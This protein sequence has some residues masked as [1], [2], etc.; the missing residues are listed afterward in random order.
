RSPWQSVLIGTA[1]AENAWHGRHHPRRRRGHRQPGGTEPGGR[2]GDPGTGQVPQREQD[3]HMGRLLARVR[4]AEEKLAGLTQALQS[5]W[6]EELADARQALEA[7]AVAARR[8]E[9][10]DEA[11]R[12]LGREELASRLQ[13]VLETLRASESSA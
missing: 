11:A 4:E 9:A 10:M 7:A 3:A 2:P 8:A 13:E 5:A 1:G 12:A 6:E